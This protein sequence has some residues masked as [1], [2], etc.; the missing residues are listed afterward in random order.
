MCIQDMRETFLKKDR[1]M[2]MDGNKNYES[3]DLM[4]LAV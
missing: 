2:L 3:F 4:L 1:T